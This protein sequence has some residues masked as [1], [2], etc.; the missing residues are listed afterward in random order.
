MRPTPIVA[1]SS[2]LDLLPM[3]LW[4]AFYP[5]LLAIVV[6]IL[7]R[8]RPRP[9]LLAYY[10]GGLT[11]SFTAAAVLITVFKAGRD[12]GVSDR[13]LGPGVDFAIGLLVL[14]LFWVLLTDRDRP[15]RERRAARKTAKA[16]NRPEPEDER[17]PWSRR[18]L[19]RDSLGL[20]FAVALVL[21]YP[22]AMYMVALKDIAQSDAGTGQTILW[23]VLY[24]LIMLAFAE[25]PI[26][27]YLVAP[28]AT[29]AKVRALQHWLGGHGRQIAM[30]LCAAAGTY[31]VLRGVINVA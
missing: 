24:N 25:V 16:A 20:T 26:V 8:P 7:G 22:G 15:L 2:F 19:D 11:M 30:G 13:A 29:G 18:L 17:E 4:S 5:T 14:V 10:F 9:L 27:M 28:E 12:V 3:A 23:V 6:I 21:N 1:V 31:L